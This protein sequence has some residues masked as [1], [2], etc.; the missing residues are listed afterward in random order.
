MLEGEYTSGTVDTCQALV[1]RSPNLP[2]RTARAAEVAYDAVADQERAATMRTATNTSRAHSRRRREQWPRQ[3][4]RTMCGRLLRPLLG[5]MRRRCGGYD[6]Q[7]VPV[8]LEVVS[9]RHHSTPP[10]G[11][12]PAVVE[13]IQ[14]GVSSRPHQALT[15]GFRRG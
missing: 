2:P 14:L 12:V 15:S 3:T 7:T 11:S 9:P 1:D 8:K 13:V 4:V 6:D 5:G 10:P